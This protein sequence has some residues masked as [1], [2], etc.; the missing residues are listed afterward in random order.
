MRLGV[1]M[2]IRF[3]CPNGHKLN[4][5]SFLA[6]KRAICPDCGAKVI[7]PSLSD[8]LAQ[9]AL[10]E[11]PSLAAIG[12]PAPQQ[13]FEEIAPSVLI[14]VEENELPAAPISAVPT[15]SP[16][17]ALPDSIIAATAAS[18]AITPQ[19]AGAPEPAYDPQRERTR[20]NQ[21]MMAVSLLFVV[22]VLAGILIW[23][24]KR[25]ASPA[26]TSEPEPAKTSSILPTT[27]FVLAQPKV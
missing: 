17:E 26:P 15:A 27:L 16:V 14:D 18:A 6:G 25:G 11:S 2:G 19:V 23:V 4:V 24:L 20:R 22:V 21:M 13:Y 12:S 3:S 10:D 8:P 9:P 5:K 7:V 1:P